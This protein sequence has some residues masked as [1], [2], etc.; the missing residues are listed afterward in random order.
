MLRAA[1]TGGI[2]TGKSYCLARFAA[3]GAAG[4]RRRPARARRRRAR[5][6]RAGARRRSASAPA[7]CCADG[8]LDRAGARPARLRRSRR[9][10]RS[11]SDRPSRGLPPDPRVVRA[12][13]R[14]ARRVAIADIPLLFETGHQHD[15]DTRHRLRLRS[16]GT[17]APPDGARRPD[18]AEAARARLA[19]A[20]ADRGKSQRARTTSSGPTAASPRRIAQVRVGVRGAEADDAESSIAESAR[21]RRRCS[22][23]LVSVASVSFAGAIRSSTNVFHSWQCGHCQ[24]SSVLR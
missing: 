21:S 13:S 8:S 2:A 24:S 22:L 19:R 6:R 11:R 23:R 16:G 3:L 9:A 15:F 14:P 20:V 12:I 4:H 1:L 18:R 5:A 10:R 7:S 17:A